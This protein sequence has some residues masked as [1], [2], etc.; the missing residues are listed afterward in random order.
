MELEGIP[1]SAASTYERLLRANARDA[2]ALR[3][4]VDR[5]L[6]TILEAAQT[7]A[8]LDTKLARAIA[9]S[10]HGILDHLAGAT[11]DHARHI[12][13]AVEYFLL[14]RDGDDDLAYA[15][16]LDDDAQVVT[17]VA[18]ALGRKDLTVPVPVR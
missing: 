4:S 17:A 16:G 12:V 1:A 5:Y 18:C 11:P 15:N 8:H 3:R 2:E 7:R 6:E 13:A 14:P 10:C 9:A